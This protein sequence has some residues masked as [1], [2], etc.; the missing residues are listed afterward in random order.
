[1]KNSAKKAKKY[2][3]LK[4]DLRVNDVNMFLIEINEIR[5][6]LSQIDEKNKIASS[7]MESANA[8]FEKIKADYTKLEQIIEEIN[9]SIENKKAT[10]NETIIN[11]EK[12][13]GQ[14][15]VIKE[16]INSAK[17]NESY[18]NQ[19]IQSITGEI[20][21]QSKELAKSEEEKEKMK[22]L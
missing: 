11:V 9:A 3:V 4:E 22:S 2:L 5:N 12:L 18:I 8:E 10:L 14:I 15:N 6:R 19:R 17:N 16:Q 21:T 1:M 7:D 13:E 20:D